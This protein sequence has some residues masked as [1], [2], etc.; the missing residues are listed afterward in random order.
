MLWIVGLGLGRALETY[1]KVLGLLNYDSNFGLIGLGQ[2][3][4]K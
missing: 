4:I 3:F 2:Y 1:L